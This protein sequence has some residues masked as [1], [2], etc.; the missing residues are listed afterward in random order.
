MRLHGQIQ[1]DIGFV[2]GRFRR[3]QVA[4]GM[5]SHTY[6]NSISL[7]GCRREYF[8]LT[9]TTALLP[10]RLPEPVS[11]PLP[12]AEPDEFV[13]AVPPFQQP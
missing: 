7:C 4:V 13:A 11:G 3:V 12:L 5:T 6:L 10:V 8:E 9:D 2:A 1:A